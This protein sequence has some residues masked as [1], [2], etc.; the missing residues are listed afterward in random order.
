MSHGTRAA[1]ERGFPPGEQRGKI[2][3]LLPGAATDRLS[4]RKRLAT[5]A[6]LRDG[7]SAEIG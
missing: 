5:H 3:A 4:A 2:S 1:V 6:R 7:C